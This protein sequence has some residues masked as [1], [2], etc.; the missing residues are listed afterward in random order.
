MIKVDGLH[1]SFDGVRALKGI[2]FEVKK[3]EVVGLL[4][5][6]GAG[7]TTTM[8]I[9][10]GFLRADAGS[11]YIGGVPIEKDLI[12]AR[13]RIGYLPEN[14]PLYPEME[15]TDFIRYIALLRGIGRRNVK[16]KVRDVLDIC[17][18]DEVVGREIGGLSRGYRQRV[19]LAASLIGE[20][21]IL[22]L[23]EPTSGLDPNQII[24][25]RGLIQ[26]LGENRTVILSTHIM[27]EVEAVCDRAIIIS[28]GE[29]V[30]DGTLAELTSK[31]GRSE[32]LISVKGSKD[33]VRKDLASLEGFSTIEMEEEDDGW[34]RVLLAPHGVDKGGEDIFRWAVSKGISLRRLSPEGVSLEDVFRNLTGGG[35]A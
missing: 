3:G 21:D 5:P 15:V 2:S 22:I 1:K 17:G 10:T 9:I 13:R 7:K 29:L 30:G 28:S 33:E 4:G 6:N 26:K 8:R 11:V 32:Y 20:P 16:E 25:I 23:D 34:I 12:G 18:L 19:G 31:G 14:A 27:Q 24:E 35:V